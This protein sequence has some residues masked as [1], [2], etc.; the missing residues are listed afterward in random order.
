VNALNWYPLT[1]TWETGGSPILNYKLRWNQG[2]SI[3]TWTDLTMMASPTTQY[4][5][6]N[7]SPGVYYEYTVRADN[8]H[9]LGPSSV[10]FTTITSQPPDAPDA[11]V[12]SV[13]LTFI[14]VTWSAPF[15]NY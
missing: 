6:T 5:Y 4:I 8:I 7:L 13:Y 12:T 10:I 2:A 11:A 1:G 9:G 3:N 15:A 14:K